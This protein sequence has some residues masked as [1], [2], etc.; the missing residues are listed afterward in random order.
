MKHVRYCDDILI[1]GRSRADCAGM[2]DIA[3]A[4]L[5]QF[6]FAVA[7]SKTVHATQRI[8]FLGV[9]ID[10]I[11]CVVACP[12]R[13]LQELRGLLAFHISH[14]PLRPVRTVLSLI[15]KLSFAAHVLPGARPF[16]R[17]LIDLCRGRRR[18]MMTL[19]PSAIDDLRYWRRHLSIW[20]GRQPW[21]LAS[22]TTT[23]AT[24]ASL[25]GWG[26]LV[27]SSSAH[28]P[29][30]LAVGSGV[31]GAWCDRDRPHIIDHRGI[32]WAELFAVLAMAAFIAPSIPNSSLVL[33]VDNRADCDII[34][35]Q[36]TRS[37]RILPLLRSLY[38]LATRHNISLFAR[39]LPGV[40]NSQALTTELFRLEMTVF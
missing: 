11:A 7:A 16:L 12:A 40:D 31:A 3:L 20:N 19:D 37:S 15:G 21:L 14:S 28:L 17:H 25:Q 1:V 4:T 35:R 29:A 22:A 13:R 32:G 23:L 39:H 27:V 33:L 9:D 30:H 34:N 10:S 6:G 18:G 36:S 24:D 2:T 26:G 38:D 5:D 8:E